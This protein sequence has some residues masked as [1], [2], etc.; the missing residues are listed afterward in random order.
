MVE[1][2]HIFNDDDF[3]RH[4][5]TA[6]HPDIGPLDDKTVFQRNAA[7][8]IVVDGED[9]LLLYTERYHD[10]TIMAEVLMRVKM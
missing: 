1:S 5:K 6:I 8:A 10:Y 4:L 7:R 9:I 2:R 3:M